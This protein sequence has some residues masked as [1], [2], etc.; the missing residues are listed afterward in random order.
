M[1]CARR[2][3]RSPVRGFDLSDLDAIG[4]AIHQLQATAAQ[5]SESDRAIQLTTARELGEHGSRLKA[6]ETGVSEMRGDVKEILSTLN[7]AKGGWRTLMMVSGVSGTIG[8]ALVWAA[9]HLKIGG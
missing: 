5:H 8:G 7:Q 3:A 4:A 1:S 6:L 9:Q 2:A